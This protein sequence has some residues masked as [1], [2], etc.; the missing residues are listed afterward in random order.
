[1]GSGFLATRERSS[2]GSACELADSRMRKRP[3]WMLRELCISSFRNQ[4]LGGFSISRE[5]SKVLYSLGRNKISQS[6]TTKP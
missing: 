1:M 6:K 5:R 3:S 4:R 2:I